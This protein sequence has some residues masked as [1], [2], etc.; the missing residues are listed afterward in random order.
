GQI[1]IT[2]SDVNTEKL[3]EQLKIAETRPEES[4]IRYEKDISYVLR[5]KEV[6]PKG[7]NTKIIFKDH[8]VYLI[9]GGLGALGILFT[10]EIL[11]Q[12]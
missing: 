2:K 10:K 8:G 9:T 3:A 7:D 4:F 11:Q 1:V 5:W 12:T 6:Q